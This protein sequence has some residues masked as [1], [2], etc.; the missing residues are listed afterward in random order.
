MRARRQKFAAIESYEFAIMFG[1]CYSGG[2]S[3]DNDDL[4]GTGRARA[5]VALVSGFS[6]ILF[7]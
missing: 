7:P 6:V 5:A 1:S 4:Q 3:D 2:M